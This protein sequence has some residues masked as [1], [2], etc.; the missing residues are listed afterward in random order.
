MTAKELAPAH[1]A[2]ERQERQELLLKSKR[3]DI[4]DLARQEIQMAQGLSQETEFQCRR[5]KSTRTS[6]Y[7]L[8]TRSSDEPMTIFVC[9]LNC[10]FRWRC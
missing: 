5:C 2:K 6:H 10:K 7:A 4:Y 3:T 9:C 1:L 8:Q